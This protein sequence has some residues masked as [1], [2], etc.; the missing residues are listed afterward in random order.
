[1]RVPEFTSFHSEFDAGWV[2]PG[3]TKDFMVNHANQTPW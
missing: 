1:M 2:V 3:A